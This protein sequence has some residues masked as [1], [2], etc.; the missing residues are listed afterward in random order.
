[1]FFVMCSSLNEIVRRAPVLL[2]QVC[3]SPMK[4]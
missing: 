2:M 1:V 4:Q 3:R